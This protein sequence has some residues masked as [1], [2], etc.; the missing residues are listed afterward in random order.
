MISTTEPKTYEIIEREFKILD[1]L[2]KPRT[3][4]MNH[5]EIRIMNWDWG[6][7]QY[8]TTPAMLLAR[9]VNKCVDI[10]KNT[11]AMP[12]YGFGAICSMNFIMPNL[13]IRIITL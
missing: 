8:G 5:D 6:D 4:F 10:I 9:N 12:R 13:E 3:Y 7:Q 2:L 11:T 1:S